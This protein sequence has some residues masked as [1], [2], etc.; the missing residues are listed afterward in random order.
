M[1]SNFQ[2]LNKIINQELGNFTPGEFVE[3]DDDDA[4][5]LG[6]L[7]ERREPI[8]GAKARKVER[9]TPKKA[10]RAIRNK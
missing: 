2:V 9:V 5:S 3:L 4:K 10:A 7:V 1:K 6:R 8:N